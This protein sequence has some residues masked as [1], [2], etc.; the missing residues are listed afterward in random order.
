MVQNHHPVFEYIRVPAY[1]RHEPESY[2]DAFGI[3]TKRK[4][5]SGVGEMPSQPG[6]TFGEEPKSGTAVREDPDLPHVPYWRPDFNCEYFEWVDIVESVLAAKDQFVMIEL[7]AGYGRWLLRAVGML[8]H[9]NPID[10]KLIGVEAEPT[11]FQW[12][13]EHLQDN[14]VRPQDYEIINAAIGGKPG[15][16]EFYF[17]NP[18]GWYGQR[19]HDHAEISE[20]L[21]LLN[22]L[23]SLVR[24]SR[25]LHWLSPAKVD[26]TWVEV[27]TLEQLLRKY[28]QVDLIDLDVQGAE[29]EV[30]AAAIDSLN[31]TTKRVH[32]GTHST[33]VETGLRDLFSRHG[34]ECSND[35]P[36]LATNQTP[37][38]EI[39]FDDGVQAW[40]NPKLT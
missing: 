23:R 36:C 2:M 8:R 37:Y 33:E 16:A 40:K 4:Y 38:G 18:T 39:V 32:I 35:Y 11:H 1:T 15:F 29:F 3:F 14:K 24:Q 7:G 17:G 13:L 9:L 34:W 31:K 22:R 10:Y 21:S 19:I 20:S 12:L 6:V 27:I 5:D 25:L 26:K 28:D 30:L